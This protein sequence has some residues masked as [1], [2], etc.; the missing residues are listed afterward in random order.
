MRSSI[1]EGQEFDQDLLN[2]L[3]AAVLIAGDLKGHR[4]GALKEGDQLA[5]GG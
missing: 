5:D 3:I 2:P 1:R 4:L